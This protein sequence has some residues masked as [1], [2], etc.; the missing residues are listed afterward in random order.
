MSKN[1]VNSTDS[2]RKLAEGNLETLDVLRSFIEVTFKESGLDPKT[3]MLVRIAALATLEASPASW[4]MNLK[5]SE[6][7]GL[8]PENIL[9]TLIAIT[10]V[11]GT[12]RVISAAASIMQALEAE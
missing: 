11:I 1:V 9:G 7:A 12:A 6:E 10:P 8:A 4:F 5:A 2:L 3:F